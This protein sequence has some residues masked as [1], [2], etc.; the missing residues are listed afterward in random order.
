MPNRPL[1]MQVDESEQRTFT[2]YTAP[3]MSFASE[4]EMKDHYRSEW[5]RYNLKRKVAGLAPLSREAFE[6]RS[7]RE[8][9]RAAALQQKSG[10]RKQ[11]REDRR[12][13]KAE[14]NSKNTQ[15]KAAGFVATAEMTAD[16]Y[17]Q[18]KMDTAATFDEGSDLFSTHRSAGLH[19]NLAH[20]ARTHGFYVPHLDYC[21]DMPGLVQYLQE[22]VYVGNV[23]LVNNKA[24]HSLEAVQSHM[25]DKGLC[26]LELEGHEEELGE[27]FDMEAL[28][29]GSPLW[30]VEEMEEEWEDVDED[31]EGE[32]EGGESSA[33]GEAAPSWLLPDGA[34]DFDTLFERAVKLGV[35]SEAEM[36]QMTDQVASGSSSEAQLIAAWRA[37]VLA[38]E[39]Q[40]KAR[41]RA[42]QDT[43][44]VSTVSRVVRYTGMPAAADAVSLS[45]KGRE[46]GHR[47]LRRFYRQSFKAHS[48]AAPP[49]CPLAG[50]RLWLLRPARGR[51]RLAALGGSTRPRRPLGARPLPRVLER[52][53]LRRSADSNL[54]SCRHL[55]GRCQPRAASPH[56]AVRDGGRALRT[57][58][59][60]GGRRGEAQRGEQDAELQKRQALRQ[61][62]RV[63][64]HDAHQ[65]LQ[66]PGATPSASTP[67]HP[68]TRARGTPR[69]ATPRHATPRHA[70]F[71]RPLSSLAW[72]WQSLNF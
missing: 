46:I 56:G 26:R 29:E 3:G 51:A 47:T 50:A 4:E 21:V 53:R 2:C 24:F 69:H 31:E 15:S 25:R 40:R 11:A 72:T 66:E 49:K 68:P 43:A 33:E 5:H 71:R 39:V 16:Q 61:D 35:V 64:Q 19:E 58:A 7:A 42:F 8:G 34:V 55:P 36:D 14:A 41:T 54:F 12:V 62:G 60:L 13:A 65:A 70:L 59:Q 45:L 9:E 18:F 17:M 32:G 63:Q 27:F 22:K 38:A 37:P 44:S 6:E 67:T 28:A 30:E 23:S 10:T 57:R 1:E 20:M 52:A 48:T